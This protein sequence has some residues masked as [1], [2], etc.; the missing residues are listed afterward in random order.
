MTSKNQKMVLVAGACGLIGA[1]ICRH[2]S[3][4]GYGVIV[5]DINRKSS[6]ELS[7]ALAG[8]IAVELDINCA[9]SI[10][11]CLKEATDQGVLIDA[12]INCAYP[13]NKNYGRHF[14]SVSY[15]DFCENV[16]L[17]LGG[18]FLMS[19]KMAI[20]FK[21]HGGG[22]I[23]NLSSIYGVV[24]P[25]FEIYEGTGMTT[26]VEYSVIKSG[27]IHL[28]QYMASY[29]R[30][31]NIRVNAISP[32]GILDAQ[33]ESFLQ[34]YRDQCFDKGMLEAQDLMG[35]VEF[36]VSDVSRYINGQNIIVDDGFTV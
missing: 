6:I 14:E 19:Q 3:A 7:K 5:A 1:S 30:G 16:N 34:G 24:A 21:R 27:L 32:G 28:T 26:P 35:T 31:N 12:I 2:L 23:V 36:L 33:P 9:D 8:A 29:F 20:Y 17:N 11:Q 10:D 15:Q 18:Y 22:N 25:K 13:R 4:A